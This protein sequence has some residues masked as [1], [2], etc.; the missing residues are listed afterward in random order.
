MVIVVWVGV[1]GGV[2]FNFWRGGG[3]GWWSTIREM[4]VIPKRTN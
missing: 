1:N 2:V 4:K 3:G